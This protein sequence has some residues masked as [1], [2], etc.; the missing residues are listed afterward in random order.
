MGECGRRMVQEGGVGN[1]CLQLH[2]A[3]ASPYNPTHT[4]DPALLCVLYPPRGPLVLALPPVMLLAL[5]YSLPSPS[6]STA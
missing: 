6:D 3:A 2:A 4:A 1:H 5:P